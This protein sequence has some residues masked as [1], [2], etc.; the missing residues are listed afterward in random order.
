MQIWVESDSFVVV[1]L[2]TDEGH[3]SHSCESL[4]RSIRELINWPWRTRI[5]QGLREDN[6][7]ADWL[8]NYAHSLSLGPH[9]LDVSPLGCSDLLLHDLAEVSFPHSVLV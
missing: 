8:A 3:L 5:T 7:V 2:V 4:V 6:G 1:T 9:V